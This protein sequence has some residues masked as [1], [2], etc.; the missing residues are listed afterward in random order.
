MKI[1]ILHQHEDK[2]VNKC[3]WILKTDYNKQTIVLSVMFLL[4]ATMFIVPV[5]TEKA[6]ASINAGAISFIG[7]WSNASWDLSAGRFVLPPIAQVVEHQRYTLI[8][9]TTGSG[10]FGGGDERGY[11]AAYTDH[12]KFYFDFFNPRKGPNTC[13][14]SPDGYGP[15]HATCTITQGVHA[16][17]TYQVFR[18]SSSSSPPLPD[19][20]GG[21]AN[22]DNEGDNSGD[23]P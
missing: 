18:V 11:V 2:C 15:I 8:W 1:M 13:E 23:S 9:V 17:A 5:I 7:P 6:L 12:F 3:R 4:V 22:S 19:A 16:R 20:N 14:V 10:L 21:D